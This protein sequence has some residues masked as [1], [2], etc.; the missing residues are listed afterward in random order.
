MSQLSPMKKLPAFCAIFACA[1]FLCTSDYSYAQDQWLVLNNGQAL[2][3]KVE[4]HDEKY[5]LAMENGS[6]IIVPK[7]QV[8]FVAETIEDIYWDKWSRVDPDDADSHVGLFRWCLKHNLLSEAQKQ[9]DLLGKLDSVDDQSDHLSRMA[10]ELELVVARIENEKKIA[11]AK[12]AEKYEIRKLPSLNP[13]SNS[14]AAVP[15]IPSVPIDA[16]G[17]PMRTQELF[18]QIKEEP[19]V[20]LVDFEEEVQSTVEKNTRRSKPAWISNRQL[21]REAKSM[22]K[23]TVAFF[24]RHIEPALIDS[25]IQCHDVRN[26]AMPLSK[27]SFGQTIPRRM[28]QQNLHFVMEQIDRSQPFS[29]PI[30]SMAQTLHG[31]Q[32]AASFDSNAPFLFELKKWTVAVSNEPEKWLMQLQQLAQ[33]TP[34]AAEKPFDEPSPATAATQQQATES[35][36]QADAY[37]PSAFNRK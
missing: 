10:E 33:T 28:S 15:T 26:V 32:K 37:D 12:A 24:R 2:Q 5:S 19:K 9:I 30:L 4:I 17:Q 35:S 1:V 8:N 7:D 36:V 25:C 20:T 16:E 3:G 31:D 6:R 11:A 27:R 13:E 29:S 14:F 18:D 21:D 23:G 34:T 22:P